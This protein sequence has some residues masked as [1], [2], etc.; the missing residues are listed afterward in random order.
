M[1]VGTAGSCKNDSA[2]RNGI[3]R[4]SVTISGVT[5]NKHAGMWRR[6]LSHRHRLNIG[7]ISRFHASSLS[8]DSQTSANTPSLRCDDVVTDDDSDDSE[9]D[10]SEERIRIVRLCTEEIM[11]RRAM[12]DGRDVAEGRGRPLLVSNSST[13]SLDFSSNDTE[14]TISGCGLR[15]GSSDAAQN[16]CIAT[17]FS[18]V[19]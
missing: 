8:N 1:T 16:P 9:D 4:A 15:P 17:C 7:N 18:P 3:E 14:S 19:Q 10:G 11:E 13:D 12:G 6:L 5:K 2:T